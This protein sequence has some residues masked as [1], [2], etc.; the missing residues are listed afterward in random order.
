MV[1]PYPIVTL[2]DPFMMVPMLPVGGFAPAP[3]ALTAAVTLAIQA[4]MSAFGATSSP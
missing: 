3:S 2:D 4:A 1:D